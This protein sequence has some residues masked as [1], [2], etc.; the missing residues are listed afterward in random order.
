MLVSICSP[1]DNYYTFIPNSYVIIGGACDNLV[2]ILYN[3]GV[4][5]PFCRVFTY[6]VA[7]SIVYRV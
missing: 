3:F 4:V 6:K 7:I 5:L 1:N 2:V